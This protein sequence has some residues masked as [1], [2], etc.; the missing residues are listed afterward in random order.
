MPL[1]SCTPDSWKH[2][3]ACTRIKNYTSDT[4][5]YSRPLKASGGIYKGKE[6][7]FGPGQHSTKNQA[8]ETSPQLPDSAETMVRESIDPSGSQID[9]EERTRKWNQG[10]DPETV[11]TKELQEFT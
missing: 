7:Y 10:I 1:L 6:L 9:W 2:L 5:L 4:G 3:V 11:M 8:K